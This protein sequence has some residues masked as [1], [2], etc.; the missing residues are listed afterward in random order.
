MIPITPEIRLDESELSFEFIRSSGPGGQNVNKVATAAQL[1]FDVPHSK[2]LPA[3]VKARLITLAGNRLTK[4]GCLLI[5]AQRYRTQEQNRQDALARLAT[6]IRKAAVRPK[7][8][9]PTRP[10]RRSE[11]RR[12][13]AKRRRGRIKAGRGRASDPEA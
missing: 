13:D 5:R 3:E 10:T 2:S 8:R 7:H 9:I 12:L 11:E 1:R 4:E 6:L